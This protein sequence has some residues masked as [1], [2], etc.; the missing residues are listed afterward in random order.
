MHAA[1]RDIIAGMIFYLL[2]GTLGICLLCVSVALYSIDQNWESTYNL[3]NPE[4]SLLCYGAF[5][6]NITMVSL[7]FHNS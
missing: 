2:H 6:A 3:E 5:V 4:K 7:K 1:R